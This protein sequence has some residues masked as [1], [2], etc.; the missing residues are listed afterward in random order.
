MGVVFPL[1][2]VWPSAGESVKPK[3]EP[4]RET[5]ARL[6]TSFLTLEV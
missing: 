6:T 4:S 1:P 2:G 5:S 3:S